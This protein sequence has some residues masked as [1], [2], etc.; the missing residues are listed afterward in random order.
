MCVVNP[1]RVKIK[2]IKI[3]CLHAL[4]LSGKEGEEFCK[5]FTDS[6]LI[7]NIN[8]YILSKDN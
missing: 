4:R 3:V 2:L 8:S 5:I 7:N 6:T 1:K